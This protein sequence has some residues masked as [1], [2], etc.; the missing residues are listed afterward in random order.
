M[1]VLIPGETD[2]QTNRRTKMWQTGR[3]A[4]RESQTARRAVTDEERKRERKKILTFDKQAKS[5]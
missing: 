2:V 3:Q 5:V 1:F 4:V